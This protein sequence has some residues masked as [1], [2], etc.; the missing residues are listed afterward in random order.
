MRRSSR[1]HCL[2]LVVLGSL[3]AAACTATPTTTSEATNDRLAAPP[4]RLSFE[5]VRSMLED[6]AGN[7]WFGSW[8]QG[9]CR[10]DGKQFTD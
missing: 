2:S 7:F 6:S 1:S 5:T 10:Y 3:W 4:A 8:N 9:V